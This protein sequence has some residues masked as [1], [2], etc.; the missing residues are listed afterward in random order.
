MLSPSY[1]RDQIRIRIIHLDC[2]SSNRTRRISDRSI[3]P[4]RQRISSGWTPYSSQR[5][6]HIKSSILALTSIIYGINPLIFSIKSTNFPTKNHHIIYRSRTHLHPSS[7]SSHGPERTTSQ[8][9]H[10]SHDH[11]PAQSSQ[12]I[13][14]RNIPGKWVAHIACKINHRA[15][16][17]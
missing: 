11:R 17:G 7:H 12:E 2:T 4:C 5:R 8:S 10:T 15:L 1:R 6:L 3:G 9:T 13:S 16:T 14:L